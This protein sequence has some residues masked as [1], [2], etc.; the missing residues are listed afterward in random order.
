DNFVFTAAISLGTGTG[1]VIQGNYIGVTKDG[2]APLQSPNGGFAIDVGADPSDPPS[3]GHAIIAGNVIFPTTTGIRMPEHG[4]G[5][6]LIQGNFIGTNAT[7][8]AGLGGYSYGI[9]LTTAL[10]T[11][12]GNVISGAS[13]GINISLQSTL[14]P[15][16]TIQGNKIGTD[17]TGAA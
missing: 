9:N 16:P 8:T 13:I 10:D 15:G 4:G 11:I 3:S 5:H 7:G 1:N 14:G 17:V 6:N 2:T 12:T